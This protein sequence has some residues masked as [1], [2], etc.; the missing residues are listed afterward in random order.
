[1]TRLCRQITPFTKSNNPR[2]RPANKI[3]RQATIT[4]TS[5]ASP[6]RPVR[7]GEGWPA[8]TSLAG[9]SGSGRAGHPA[10]VV[11]GGPTGARRWPGNGRPSNARY[12]PIRLPNRCN[13]RFQSNHHRE[14]FCPNRISS[15]GPKYNSRSAAVRVWSELDSPAAS[16]GHGPQHDQ[17]GDRHGDPEASGQPIRPSIGSST[18]NRSGYV[19]CIA[20]SALDGLH[21]NSTPTSGR[22]QR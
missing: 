20:D 11:E 21:G 8:A 22:P 15:S 13:S 3:A 14:L 2:Q 10:R 12:V 17:D 6:R 7:R 5:A 9:A 18:M 1:M 16:P 19:C 4:T